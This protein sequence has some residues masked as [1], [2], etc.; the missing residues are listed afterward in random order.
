M[1]ATSICHSQL[2]FTGQTF[3]AVKVNEVVK[4]KTVL[5]LEQHRAVLKKPWN[6]GWADSLD[7]FS[8]V[9]ILT[10]IRSVESGRL[11]TILGLSHFLR[12]RIN[13]ISP[14]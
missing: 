8:Q 9:Q 13:S 3:C 2:T 14:T 4:E 10:P 6:H 7:R 11:L 12:N 5:S 1:T